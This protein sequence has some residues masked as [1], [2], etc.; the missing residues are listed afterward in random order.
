MTPPTQ[1]DPTPHHDTDHTEDTDDTAELGDPTP[2]SAALPTGH[3]PASAAP[4]GPP[5]PVYSGPSAPVYRSGPAPVALVLGLLGLLAAISVFVVEVADVDI[6]WESA[7][8]W[9][10]VV[11]GVAVLLVG[12]IGLRSSRSRS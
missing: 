3:S 10:L 9:S 8:P 5:T 6:S 12:A 2:P 7:G 4:P 1:S 11:A